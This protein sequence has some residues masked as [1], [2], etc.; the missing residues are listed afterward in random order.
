MPCILKL[1]ISSVIFLV[2]APP[3]NGDRQLQGLDAKT[4]LVATEEASW[5]QDFVRLAGTVET[6][7]KN[8]W[9]VGVAGGGLAS[10]CIAV[11]R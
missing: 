10:H 11:V 1:D 9:K 4:K 6:G 5:F 2:I 7:D 3:L 8:R